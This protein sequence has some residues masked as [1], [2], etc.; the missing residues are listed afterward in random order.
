MRHPAT[1]L[2]AALLAATMCACAAGPRREL[3][4]AP[5]TSVFTCGDAARFSVRYD[6][7]T[8]GAARPGLTLR[9][10][11]AAGDRVVRL[12]ADTAA[13]GARY[14]GRDAAGDVTL[15]ERGGEA[16]LA[17]TALPTRA[18]RGEDA[19][20][21][22][23][24]AR[25]LG[26]E[27][28]ALGQEPGWTVEVDEGR[29]IQFV[30]DYGSTRVATP[31]PPPTTETAGEP[32]ANRVT[33]TAR[34]EAHALVLDVVRQPCRDAMSGERFPTTAV[35]RLDGREYRGCGRWLGP[36]PRN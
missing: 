36:T 35:V 17:G 15:L 9:L 7:P 29:R 23:D 8:P 34:A 11:D 19:A 3:A 26:A 24:E 32:G 12:A 22:W 14:R 13:S 21:A 16:T 28:R 31:A 25:L 1:T 20:S 4:A 5:R 2:P 30:G 27:Y 33:Y 6:A 18:C 10:V